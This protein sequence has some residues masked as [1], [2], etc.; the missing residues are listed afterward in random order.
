M[1]KM[2]NIN[3]MDK[4]NPTVQWVGGKGRLLERIREHL[5]EE[6]NTYHEV[7]LGGGSLLLSLKPTKAFCYELNE[8][9]CNLYRVIKTDSE[10]LILKLKEIETEYLK[11]NGITEE[12][13]AKRKEFYIDIRTCF[14]KETDIFQKSVYFK[15]IN[16]T[17]FNAL[18]RENQSGGFNVPFGKG[19]DPTICDAE[20]IKQLSLYLN[21]NDIMI[22]SLDF[23]E[24]LVNIKE[25][26]FVYLDPPY[27][28][29]KD[30]SFTNYTKKGFVKTDHERLIRYC[31]KLTDMNVKFILSN[32]NCDFIKNSFLEDP[33]T[34]YEMSVARTLNSKKDCRSK[35]KCEI[36]IKNF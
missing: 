7:F 28:P 17:C 15:F 25:G 1:D 27:Y 13:L 26:D 12:G 23:E 16:K 6:Y 36:I 35:S 2:D 10:K 29:L 22:S 11:I 18:Y 3:K 4:I 20:N 30:N 21:E 19:R 34:I 14:N 9:L 8:N 32:S 24:S 31:K 5:P 33:Y